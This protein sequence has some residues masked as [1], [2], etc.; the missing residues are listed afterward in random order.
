ME[1]F[2]QINVWLNKSMIKLTDNWQIWKNCKAKDR[3]RTNLKNDEM[4]TNKP[5]EKIYERFEEPSH[6]ST[7]P[8][9]KRQNKTKK[10]C[11]N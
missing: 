8:N 6:E 7:T 1:S 2:D 4:W 5:I 11:S 10:W 3:Q 9:G